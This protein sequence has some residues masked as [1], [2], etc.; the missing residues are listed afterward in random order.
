M[1]DDAFGLAAQLAYYFLLALFPALI[2][3][4]AAASFLPLGDFTGE[5]TAILSP[6]VPAEVLELVRA[7]MLEIAKGDDGGLVGLGLVGAVWSS[8]AALVAI[9]SA[10]NR[11]YDIE[12]SRSWWRVRVLAV[13]LTV[14]LALF[15]SLSALL[16]LA[17]PELAELL[18]NRFGLGSAFVWLWAVIRWP[19]AFLLVSAAIAIVYYFAPDAEQEWEWVTPGSLVATFLWLIGSL[20]FRMYVVNFGHYEDT[21]GTIGAVIVLMLWFYLSGLVIVIGAEMN[22]ELEHA[23]PWGKKPGEKVPGPRKQIGRA[24]ARAY[25]REHPEVGFQL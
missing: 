10:M 22:A 18:A 7:Q 25:G 1:N 5:V 24:A 16:V 15:V 23:S 2:C 19:I 20:A 17:G 21:Y 14:G 13:G 11:A 6:L 3:V 8:S 12:E 4:L 9:V